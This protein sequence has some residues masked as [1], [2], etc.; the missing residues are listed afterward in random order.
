MRLSTIAVLALTIA[1]LLVFP[2]KSYDTNQVFNAVEL[3]HITPGG[4]IDFID[5][6]SDLDGDR[7]PD[8]LL[9][10]SSSSGLTTL[11]FLSYATQHP[12]LFPL[13]LPQGVSAVALLED[14]NN[15]G[16]PEVAIG[17]DGAR[18][19]LYDP[20]LQQQLWN[21]SLEIYPLPILDLCLLHDIDDDGVGEL[22]ALTPDTL[23]CISGSGGSVLWKIKVHNPLKIAVLEEDLLVI[24]RDFVS[25]IY[26]ASGTTCWNRSIHGITAC[27]VA[28]DLTGD[29]VS[30]IVVGAE[31]NL[32][33][34][35][36]GREGG[37]VGFAANLDGRP[38]ALA[39]AD[40]NG[41]NRNEILVA[42]SSRVYVFAP[43]YLVLL[44]FIPTPSNATLL[45]PLPDKSLD[46]AADFLLSTLENETYLYTWTGP[47]WCWPVLAQAAF[48]VP[49]IN[50]D[51]YPEVIVSDKNTIYCLSGCI[52]SRIC[53]TVEPSPVAVHQQVQISGYLLPPIALAEL[54]VQIYYE[55]DPTSALTNIIR[56]GT[57]GCFSTTFVP[58]QRGTLLI[59]VSWAGDSQHQG[60]ATLTMLSVR[61]VSVNL[62]CTVSP[63]SPQ[64][65]EEVTILVNAS[66]PISGSLLLTITPPNATSL[67]VPLPISEGLAS[68]SFRVDAD[69]WWVLHVTWAGDAVFEPAE[70][71]TSFLVNPT[72]LQATLRLLQVFFLAIVALVALLVILLVVHRRTLHK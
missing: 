35:L 59:N 44:R 26:A 14:L 18:V 11:V 9:V 68:T 62:T 66:Q 2:C 71:E 15:D 17:Y 51:T 52:I 7:L 34:I 3:W 39:Y 60:C 20:F 58:T 31:P 27:S 37:L 42:A 5:I 54:Q 28:S 50:S 67:E 25:R 64:V 21:V 22:A 12:I 43:P 57:E 47:L 63:S 13:Q 4:S 36:D 24:A 30:D 53:V 32:L 69:G 1:L 49:D 19:A 6:A 16:F 55:N 45:T 38:D 48:S 23:A 65:G 29:N 33:S 61:G 10:N 41:D 56:T 72:P 8:I 40:V 46:G 70:V